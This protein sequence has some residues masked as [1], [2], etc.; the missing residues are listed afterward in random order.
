MKWNL[1]MNTDISLKNNG[2]TILAVKLEWLLVSLLTHSLSVLVNNLLYLGRFCHK[3]VFNN[4]Q[5]P[6]LLHCK[7]KV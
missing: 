4:S 1:H 6:F 5:S 3:I 7:T 2:G